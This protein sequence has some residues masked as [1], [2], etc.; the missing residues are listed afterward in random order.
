MDNNEKQFGIYG[1]AAV[2]NSNIS[3]AVGPSSFLACRPIVILRSHMRMS[4]DDCTG[5]HAC[6]TAYISWLSLCSRDTIRWL[7]K[8]PQLHQQAVWVGGGLVLRQE[9]P[10]GDVEFHH[11]GFLDI[12]CNLCIEQLRRKEVNGH[13]LL[14]ESFGI[15]TYTSIRVVE[16]IFHVI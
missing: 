14:A 15:Y 2:I 4:S 5:H 3:K 7:S 10:L 13:V 11:G 12:L 9:N 1:I 6:A 16:E 8:V